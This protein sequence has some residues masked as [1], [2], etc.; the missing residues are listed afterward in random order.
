VILG[1]EGRRGLVT[2]GSKGL[3]FAIARELVGE[4]ALVAICSRDEDEIAAAAGELRSTGGV[5][6][7]QRA[8][9]TDPEQVRDFVARSAE[10]LGG[11]DFLVNNAG[12]AHPGTFQSLT[13]SDWTSDLDVKLF[14]LARGGR[15]SHRQ[16]RIRV[17]ALSRPGILRD[18]GEPRRRQLVHESARSGGGP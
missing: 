15:R 17:F 6:I 4:G 12:R 11:I 18:V 10:E 7:A 8:D 9:V 16:H 2:G 5:V 3:G 1:L 13:D 14:S